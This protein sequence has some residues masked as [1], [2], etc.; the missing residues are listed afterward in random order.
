MNPM[1]VRALVASVPAFLLLVYSVAALVA[2]HTLS[3]V[4]QLVG[5]TSGVEWDTTAVLSKK[6]FTGSFADNSETVI[7][8][9]QLC[10]DDT[11]WS[12]DL[13]II[14]RRQ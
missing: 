13:Q 14:Y 11:H 5:A 3:A 9:W 1:L 4:L 2:H 10:R 7:G 12:D 6:R 8:R